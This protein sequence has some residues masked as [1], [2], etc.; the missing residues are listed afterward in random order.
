MS[1]ELKHLRDRLAVQERL[2]TSLSGS[3]EEIANQLQEITATMATREDIKQLS[4]S[5]DDRFKQLSASVDDR[6]KQLSASV[7][8]RFKQ[9]STS[10]DDRFKQLSTS[11]DQRFD[12]V[13]GELADIKS[14]TTEIRNIL[15]T[16]VERLNKPS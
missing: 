3:V 7:D 11:V 8:D 12:H 4:A 15:A 10:V 1:A 16:L 5:V 14:D 6:F 9:L 13:Y 2:T